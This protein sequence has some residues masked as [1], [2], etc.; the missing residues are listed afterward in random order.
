MDRRRA[1]Q[2][3]RDRDAWDAYDALFSPVVPARTLPIENLYVL[4]IQAVYSLLDWL[5][6]QIATF[7]TPVLDD[8]GAGPAESRC[9]ATTRVPKTEVRETPSR[10]D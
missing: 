3:R 9:T 1:E 10:D 5:A 7:S 4:R 2:F 8:G 6:H